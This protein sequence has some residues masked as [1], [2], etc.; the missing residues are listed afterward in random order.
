MERGIYWHKTKKKL[1][2][3]DEAAE[4]IQE[5]LALTDESAVMYYA[6]EDD[7]ILKSQEVY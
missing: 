3:R 4:V 2:V 1:L 7:Y 6:D 5:K